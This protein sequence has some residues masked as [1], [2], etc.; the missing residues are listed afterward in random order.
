MWHISSSVTLL[1][2][3]S[4]TPL[5]CCCRGC[6]SLE[7]DRRLRVLAEMTSLHE[8]IECHSER[9]STLLSSCQRPQQLHASVAAS[10]D[11]MARIVDKSATVVSQARASEHCDSS[12]VATLLELVSQSRRIID[13]ATVHIGTDATAA[14]ELG[15]KNLCF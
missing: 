11:V 7:A 1:S 3:L 5:L 13:S 9:L 15:F 14:V 12:D 8:T 2:R 6:T 4:V 10:S